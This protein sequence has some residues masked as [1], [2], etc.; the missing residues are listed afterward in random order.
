MGI[1]Y[2][3]PRKPR[4]ARSKGDIPEDSMIPVIINKVVDGDDCS[5]DAI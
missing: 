4:V 1:A 5:S 3:V 2:T